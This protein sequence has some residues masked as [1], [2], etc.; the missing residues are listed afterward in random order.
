MMMLLHS[1]IART[2][3]KQDPRGTI[4]PDKRDTKADLDQATK[5][6]A[7]EN[8]AIFAKSRA[9]DKKNAGRELKKKNL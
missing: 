6:I 3:R 2:S 1:S 8:F 4:R 9:T 5:P 7:T